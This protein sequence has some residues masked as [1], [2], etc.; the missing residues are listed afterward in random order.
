MQK[1]TTYLRH[2]KY[3]YVPSPIYLHLLAFPS[4][5]SFFASLVALR[6]SYTLNFA[7]TR[8]RYLASVILPDMHSAPFKLQLGSCI[9]CPPM[10]SVYVLC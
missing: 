2:S 4:I 1:T 5:L 8:Y 9:P 7:D 6:V 10:P 3:N